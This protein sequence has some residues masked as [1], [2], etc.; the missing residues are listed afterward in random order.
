[1]KKIIENLNNELSII[2]SDFDDVLLKAE[3]AIEVT[4]KHLEKL[5]L[6][7]S[8]NG[9]KTKNSE[10]EFFKK[11]R[12]RVYFFNLSAVNFSGNVL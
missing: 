11:F 5:R 3:K 2:E 9:F 6:T 1:M 12:C 7:I 4:K 10:I 8:T